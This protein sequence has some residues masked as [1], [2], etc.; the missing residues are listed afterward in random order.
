MRIQVPVDETIIKKSRAVSVSFVLLAELILT[1]YYANI[2]ANLK[3][4]I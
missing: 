2:F 1:Q 3:V 4:R